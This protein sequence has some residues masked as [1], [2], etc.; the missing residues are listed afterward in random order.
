[1]PRSEP[2]PL[3]RAALR[4]RQTSQYPLY[5]FALTGRELSEVAEIS[6]LGRDESGQLVGYQREVAGQHVRNILEYLE[7]GSV[8][9]PN[10]II[11][12]LTQDV[13]F[14]PS[15]GNGGSGDVVEHGTVEIPR[16]SNGR[17]VAW[18]VDGQQRATALAQSTQQD[19]PV[20]INAF[21]A[22]DV[23]TQREHFLRVNTT[24]SLP[25]GL[26]TELLPEISTILPSHLT[27]NRLPATL[28][29]FLATDDASPLHDLI[30]RSSTPPGLRRI[31]V[32]RDTVIVRILRESLSTPTGCL[33]PYRNIATGEADL[34]RIQ[35]LLVTYW[36][37]VRDTF[38]E[39]WALPPS[40]SRLMHSAGMRAMGRLMDRV[41]SRIDPKATG[42]DRQV[43][44]DL[45]LIAESCRWTSG[46]WEALGGLRWNELQN[47][48]SHIRML[49][50]HLVTTYLE[51]AESRE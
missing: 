34:A 12:A 5:L 1:M 51:A 41:M 9:F 6:R 11:L 50:R 33:F 26:I 8:L 43:R 2:K 19:L 45:G 42:A 27:Q 47:V 15:R 18:I 49:S 39:A 4:V 35:A 30:R 38:P 20:P 31:A 14:T 10:S 16:S 36:S 29:H 21:L 24:K 48:P 13:R 40:R 37:A 28:C 44:R 46:S 22:P 25:K 23:E 3:K 32:V 7:S 17:K